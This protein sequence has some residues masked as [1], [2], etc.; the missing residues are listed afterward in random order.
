MAQVR[1][2]INAL[3]GEVGPGTR[4]MRSKIPF[5]SFG[6]AW[7]GAIKR[8][9]SH[10]KLVG[11]GSPTDTLTAKRCDSCS[12]DSLT[13]APSAVFPSV[14]KASRILGQLRRGDGHGV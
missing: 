3:T 5:L 13:S 6:T 2:L 11:N 1:V 4:L 10:T 9:D 12:I 14:V 7:D 8:S